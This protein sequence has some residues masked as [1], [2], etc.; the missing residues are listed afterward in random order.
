MLHFDA[1]VAQFDGV[2]DRVPSGVLLSLDAG[3]GAIVANRAA[4]RLFGFSWN[5]KIAPGMLS[6]CTPVTGRKVPWSLLPLQRAMDSNAPVPAADYEILRSDGMRKFATMSAS[7]L[8]DRE[9]RVRGGV[10]VLVDVTY[11]R[12]LEK[13]RRRVRDSLTTQFTQE[14]EVANAFQAAQFPERLPDA[15]GFVLSALYCAADAERIGGDWY[16]AFPLP[17]GRIGLSIGDVMGHGLD[18]AVT[19][20][21]L[22]QAIQAAAFIDPDPRVML[23]AASSTL[24]LHDGEL[25]ASAVAGILHPEA[26]T[27]TFAAAGHPLPL[28]RQRDA[29]LIE[30]RGAA[31]PL[32]FSPACDAQTHVAQ[33]APGDA[34]V[35]YTDGLIEATRDALAG[36]RMLHNAVAA[37]DRFD[38][39][40]AAAH[41]R[42]LVLGSRES[43]DDIAILTVARRVTP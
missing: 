19:M 42:E 6:V 28:I 22:R 16:D 2:M 8:H 12:S 37:D 29:T 40:D 15:S 17:D 43:P 5:Q 9:G 21:K 35:F 10:A 41:L 20:G 23:D 36:E 4:R 34:A 26:A 39:D 27:L 32:G 25:I 7:P 1:F 24:M 30:F 31:A 18:A 11:L 38:H 14:K 3:G 33:L 13:R